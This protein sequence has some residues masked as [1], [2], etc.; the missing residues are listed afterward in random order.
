MRKL[1]AAE[2]EFED[3]RQHLAEQLAETERFGVVRYA[4]SVA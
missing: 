4:F 1:L 2:R 3:H